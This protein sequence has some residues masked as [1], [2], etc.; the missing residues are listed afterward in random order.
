MVAQPR[1][2]GNHCRQPSSPP[3]A[4]LLCPGRGQGGGLCPGFHEALHRGICR[5][6]RTVDPDAT[7]F[8]ELLTWTSRLVW[9]GGRR[10]HGLRSPIESTSPSPWCSRYDSPALP[11][12]RKRKNRPE[13]AR[14]LQAM[15][16]ELHPLPATGKNTFW[17]A[18]RPSSAKPAL[19]MDM[20]QGARLTRP[21]DSH[22]DCRH[23]QADAG[24]G[25]ANFHN[26]TLWNYTADNSNEAGRLLERRGLCPSFSRDQQ[27]RSQRHTTPALRVPGS[28]GAVNAATH[29]Q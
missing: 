23:G 10:Q 24:S 27:D 14:V 29:R 15:I 2:V 4:P 25:Y 21:G 17:A 1:R 28:R 6:I 8:M 12:T 3:P 20:P 26:F 19:A 22:P 11:S 18:C 16:K 7:I 13:V 9:T 5:Q